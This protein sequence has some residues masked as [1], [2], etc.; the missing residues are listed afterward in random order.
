MAP[1]APPMKMTLVRY[2]ATIE[3]VDED[4]SGGFEVREMASVKFECD[5]EVATFHHKHTLAPMDEGSG[6]FLREARFSPLDTRVFTTT[7]S[8][9]VCLQHALKERLQKYLQVTQQVFDDSYYEISSEAL[10]GFSDIDPAQVRRDLEAIGLSDTREVT[11]QT[12]EAVENVMAPEQTYSIS[13]THWGEVSLDELKTERRWEGDLCKAS[14]PSKVVELRNIPAKW[15][16]GADNQHGLKKEDPYG[17]TEDISWAIDDLDQAVAFS[18]I[19]PRYYNMPFVHAMVAPFEPFSS[20]GASA[21]FFLGTVLMGAVK[22]V[23]SIVAEQSLLGW[24]TSRLKPWAHRVRR[25][26]S[27]GQAAPE[28]ERASTEEQQADSEDHDNSAVEE[29]HK[30]EDQR[31]PEWL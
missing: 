30:G 7:R 6:F 16:S 27:N 20:F 14:C 9:Q 17:G 3:P 5:K 10:G 12:F 25:E 11:Y 29:S 23:T 4:G 2:S 1:E 15:F 13:I 28:E 19:A 26:R 24:W 8:T 31:G 21:A 18:Y 22:F